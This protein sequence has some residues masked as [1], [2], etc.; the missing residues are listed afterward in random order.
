MTGCT[1]T[2]S[3][4]STVSVGALA[5]DGSATLVT[6]PGTVVTQMIVLAVTSVSSSTSNVGLSEFQA[7]GSICPGC[8]LG[9]NFTDASATT[10]TS[11]GV[12]SGTGA[13][14]D[15]A[16]LA[17]ASAS[18]YGSS[19]P[20]QRAIDGVISGY[21]ANYSAEW[22][23]AGETTGAWLNLTWDAYY[24]VDSVVLYVSF[25]LFLSF[26]VSEL[27]LLASLIGSTQHQRLDHWWYHSIR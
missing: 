18:S 5:N 12:V 9:N 2:F 1:L 11:S 15:L 26:L 6:L 27:T 13:F 7:F 16:L 8:A 19:Q 3:D 17:T 25:K 4:G 23:T 22:A 10:T 24:L 21:P 14:A 20:P